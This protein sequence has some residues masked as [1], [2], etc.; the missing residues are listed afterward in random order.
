MHK[1]KNRRPENWEEAIKDIKATLNR[2]Q[3]ENSFEL[4]TRNP[5]L[6]YSMKKDMKNYAP[7][8]LAGAGLLT[9]FIAFAYW[10]VKNFI[11]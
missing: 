4:E 2:Y 10:L 7:L 3:D 8:M 6:I 5:K 9:L 1:D 11:P